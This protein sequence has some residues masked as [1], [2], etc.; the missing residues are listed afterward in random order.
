MKTHIKIKTCVY[1]ALEHL[2]YSYLYT[3]I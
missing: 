1:S 2:N 3:W